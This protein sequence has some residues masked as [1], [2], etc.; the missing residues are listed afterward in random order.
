VP[1]RFDKSCWEKE[2]EFLDNNPEL[3][4]N[5]M[6]ADR[7]QLL[8]KVSEGLGGQIGMNSRTPGRP[9]SFTRHFAF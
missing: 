1:A 3:L 9:L 8:S 5:E 4:E 7:H 2:K 6:L